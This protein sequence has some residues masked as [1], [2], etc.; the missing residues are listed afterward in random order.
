MFQWWSKIFVSNF[1]SLSL[2]Q[3][4]ENN[5]VHNITATENH[6]RTA[7]CSHLML[8][9]LI[10]TL[11]HKPFLSLSCLSQTSEPFSFHKTKKNNNKKTIEAFCGKISTIDS[12]KLA[13]TMKE[14][15]EAF[16][17]RGWVQHCACIGINIAWSQ[18]ALTWRL[19]KKKDR[20]QVWTFSH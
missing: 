4:Q 13:A 1:K 6:D 7:K 15:T 11:T 2:H 17:S 18:H 8:R 20:Q 19:D 14:T 3:R 16:P 10:S 5:E 9:E 12:Q